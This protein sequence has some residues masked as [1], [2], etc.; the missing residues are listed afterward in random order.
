MRFCT[1]SR[2]LVLIAIS[3]SLKSAKFD[4]TSHFDCIGF[5]SV[6][7]A[8]EQRKMSATF[9]NRRFEPVGGKSLLRLIPLSLLSQ[10][11]NGWSRINGSAAQG[12]L[13][14][15]NEASPCLPIRALRNLIFARSQ[16][17]SGAPVLMAHLGVPI[18]QF[19]MES[20]S[21]D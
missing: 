10:E 2:S 21:I 11:L 3:D 18:D 15:S 13:R 19:E 12:R 4:M 7:V 1:D 20:H 17:T 5:V 14:G 6:G 9:T 16:E 8:E